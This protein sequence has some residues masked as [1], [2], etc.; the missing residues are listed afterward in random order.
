MNNLCRWKMIDVN[1]CPFCLSA[2]ESIDHLLLNC[3]LGQDI[4][5]SATRFSYSAFVTLLT[6]ESLGYGGSSKGK[7]MWRLSSSQQSGLFVRKGTRGSLNTNYLTIQT[8]LG[9]DSVL[10]HGS[11]I[12]ILLSF[13]VCLS[14]SSC[15]SK[16]EVA[17]SQ[18]CHLLPLSRCLLVD[19]YIVSFLGVLF[20]FPMISS[21]FIL[22]Y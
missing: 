18:S 16:M 1:S 7:I 13:G 20:F 4:W 12:S 8:L 15:L 2:E 6:L 10:Q 22:Y 21:I 3:M 5:N 19:L 17:T 9:Q 14:M 11:P